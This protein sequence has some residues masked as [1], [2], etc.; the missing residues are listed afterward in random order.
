M[1][2]EPAVCWNASFISKPHHAPMFRPYLTKIQYMTK[3][4]R[5]VQCYPLHQDF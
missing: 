5:P 3:A 1:P 2:T 4:Q